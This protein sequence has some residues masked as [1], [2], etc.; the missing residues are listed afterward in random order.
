MTNSQSKLA[1]EED[2]GNRLIFLTDV[3]YKVIGDRDV[4]RNVFKNLDEIES[5]E[6]RIYHKVVFDLHKAITDRKKLYPGTTHYTTMNSPVPNLY[7][8]FQPPGLVCAIHLFRENYLQPKF[9]NKSYTVKEKIMLAKQIE[10]CRGWRFNGTRWQQSELKRI[11]DSIKWRESYQSKCNYKLGGC[12]LMIKDNDVLHHPKWV[13]NRAESFTEGGQWTLGLKPGHSGRLII[14]FIRTDGVGGMMDRLA[15]DYQM[16]SS[17]YWYGGMPIR[18]EH[19]DYFV[20]LEDHP[21]KTKYI[22]SYGLS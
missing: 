14:E 20:Y 5:K 2:L 18:K 8:R 3:L 10:K 21:R 12:I 16:Y 6:E 22:T 4:I 13:F 15:Y 19:E 1:A 17:G 7:R 11:R 9:H